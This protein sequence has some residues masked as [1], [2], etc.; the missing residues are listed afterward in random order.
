MDVNGK[1]KTCKLSFERHWLARDPEFPRNSLKRIAALRDDKSKP[2]CGVTFPMLLRCWYPSAT[3]KD[4]R[5][6]MKVAFPKEMKPQES[7]KAVRRQVCIFNFFLQYLVFF[8][9]VFFFFCFCPFCF[10][11]FYT[12]FFEHFTLVF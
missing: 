11:F 9:S 5:L 6:L 8:C 10:L 3:D 7:K 12:F 1:Q 4:I 2:F